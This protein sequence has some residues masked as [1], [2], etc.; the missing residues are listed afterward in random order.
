MECRRKY[1]RESLG[2]RER[3][4]GNV[5]EKMEK[6]KSREEYWGYDKRNKHYTEKYGEEKEVKE[7]VEWN[8]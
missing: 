1:Y 6:K 2:K 3:D 5:W 8:C 7:E 4:K